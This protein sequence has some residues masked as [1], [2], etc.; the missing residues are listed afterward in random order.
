MA[1]ALTREVISSLSVEDLCHYLVDQKQHADVVSAMQ[2]NRITGNDFL[3][4]SKDQLKELFPIL[5]TRMSVARLLSVWTARTDEQETEA[6]P[7]PQQPTIPLPIP[8]PGTSKVQYV[9]V[10]TG[11]KISPSIT[12]ETTCTCHAL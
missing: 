4:L 10:L 3:E 11:A 6:P 9:Y 1:G 2:D 7:R 5:G 12:K 8:S